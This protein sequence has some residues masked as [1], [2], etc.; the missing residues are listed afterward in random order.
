LKFISNKKAGII[1]KDWEVNRE[2]SEDSFGTDNSFEEELDD[3]DENESIKDA[4]ALQRKVTNTKKSFQDNFFSS[5]N[6]LTNKF[7]A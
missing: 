4:P 2:E 5:S 6:A 7:G 3:F 1:K